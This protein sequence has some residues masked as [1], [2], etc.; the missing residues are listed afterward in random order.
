MQYFGIDY[1]FVGTFM[2]FIGSL[3]WICGKEK[4]DI[5]RGIV[6]FI[7]SALATGQFLFNLINNTHLDAHQFSD[8]AKTINHLMLS[9]MLIDTYLLY[10]YGC[11]RTSLWAHHIWGIFSY[12]TNASFYHMSV[13]PIGEI[14]SA[15][16]LFKLR[17]DDFFI[18]NNNISR[19]I[20][21]LFIRIP[22]WLYCYFFMIYNLDNFGRFYL[23]KIVP[24]TG[25]T[26]LMILDTIWI[27][28]NIESI[29]KNT[30]EYFDGELSKITKKNK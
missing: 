12:I 25:L 22:L 14:V 3:A 21:F 26:M 17:S 8:L 27:N 16:Y 29:F 23:A 18:K 1:T 19:I 15:V 10:L 24:L 20:I 11:K 13:P 4:Q 30:I 5:Y 9:Y 6:C 2:F 7:V 28:G